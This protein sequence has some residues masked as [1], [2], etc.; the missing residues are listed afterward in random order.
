MS[1]RTPLAAIAILGLIALP[2]L[3]PPAS[4]ANFGAH[5]GLAQATMRD[6]Y[7]E[8]G[9]LLADAEVQGPIAGGA[10]FG[11]QVAPT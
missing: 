11:G 3:G 2:A 4:A 1:I 8:A 10:Y 5:V 9:A 7:F 6:R